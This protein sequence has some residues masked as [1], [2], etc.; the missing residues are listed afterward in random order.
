LAPRLIPHPNPFRDSLR[1]SQLENFDFRKKKE[2]TVK[3][4]AIEEKIVEGVKGCK[5]LKGAK[6]L[7]KVKGIIQ[8]TTQ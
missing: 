8:E 2:R 4:K 6:L 3:R 7:E 1:S 5:G